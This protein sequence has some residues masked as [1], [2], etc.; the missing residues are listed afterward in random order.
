MLNTELLF[1][2]DL[3]VCQEDSE[4]QKKEYKIR[5]HTIIFWNLES[6]RD[7][8]TQ[9][10][11]LSGKYSISIKSAWENSRPLGNLLEFNLK[12][13]RSHWNLLEDNILLLLLLRKEKE[14]SK[15]CWVDK[16][17]RKASVL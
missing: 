12:A 15:G 17:R 14:D 4:A 6:I 13:D 9:A 16:K 1:A 11:I 7:S 8:D 10:Q 3:G 5:R 2:F